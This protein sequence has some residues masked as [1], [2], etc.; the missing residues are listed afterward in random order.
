MDNEIPD[1]VIP[2]ES[3]L[4]TEEN[5]ISVNAVKD[6]L[7]IEEKF[8]EPILERIEERPFVFENTNIFENNFVEPV[9]ETPI[10]EDKELVEEIEVPKFNFEKIVEEA[11]KVEEE[12]QPEIYTKG[13]Q[14]FSSVYV[15]ERKEEIEAPKVEDAKIEMPLPKSNDESDFELPVLKKEEVKEEKIE[16]PVLNDY[17]L[18]NL[19][20]E[21]YTINK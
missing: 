21:T 19:S 3:V 15:P 5:V 8:E 4:E 1:A 9:V 12:K 2:V 16:V 7:K 17:D 13:P 10:I 11:K 20:G 6:D 14:I 18:D